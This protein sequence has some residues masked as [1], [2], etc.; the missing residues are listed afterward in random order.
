VQTIAG[1]LVVAA[2]QVTQTSYTPP[3]SSASRQTST[4]TST[5]PPQSTPTSTT[6]DCAAVRSQYQALGQLIL[7]IR[8]ALAGAS[9]GSQQYNSLLQQWQALA[10][11]QSLL[12]ARNQGCF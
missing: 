7:S 3:S 10:Y 4:S 11:Q 1:T 6:T 12:V 5:Q 9:A 8:E 2:P